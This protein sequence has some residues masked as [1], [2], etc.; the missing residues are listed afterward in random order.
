MIH[1]SHN[2]TNCTKWLIIGFQ[3]FKQFFYFY[4]N[5]ILMF[6]LTQLNLKLQYWLLAKFYLKSLLDS[7]L[8]VFNVRSIQAKRQAMCLDMADLFT[9]GQTKTLHKKIDQCLACFPDKHT[10]PLLY[11]VNNF[12]DLRRLNKRYDKG[13]FM[14]KKKS[15]TRYRA[16]KCL[17]C[18]AVVK[19]VN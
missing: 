12:C 9:P 15:W 18:I 6:Q 7:S 14:I 3:L 16:S 11:V 10:L 4:A 13:N 5:N 19:L 1:V 8:F 17:A 2:S